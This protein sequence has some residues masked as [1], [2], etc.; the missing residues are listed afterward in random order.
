MKYD[1]ETFETTSGW[2]GTGSV[3]V[4]GLNENTE[5]IASLKEKSLVFHFPE[6]S[7][8]ESITKSV[9]ASIGDYDTVVF[10]L[11]SRE[12]RSASYRKSSDC[13]YKISFDADNEFFIR[14]F[15]TFTHETIDISG[16]SSIDRIK[17]TCL[18]DDEDYLVISAMYLEK[19]ELPIDIFTAISEHIDYMF[20]IEYGKGIL[21]G[22]LSGSA[23]D[24]NV[25]LL[26]NFIGRY[27]VILIDDDVNSE[28]HQLGERSETGFGLTDLFDGNF[29]VNNFTDAPVYLI[30]PARAG[31][32]S[33]E[34]EIQLPGFSVWGLVP[35]PVN[36]G[37]DLDTFLD[38]FQTLTIGN[39]DQGRVLRYPILV[40]CEARSYEILMNMS[41]L[42]KK[43]LDTHTLWI[44]GR[45][46]DI[47]YDVIPI[48]VEPTSSYDVIP[49]IQYTINVEVK[50]ELW[51]RRHLPI[52]G[53]ATLN[54]TP[55]SQG[56]LL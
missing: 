27:S 52:A 48:E 22:T 24:T 46:N 4:H 34:I 30:F 32:G 2:S 33:S 14:T 42:I 26:E 21:L 29:L 8:G 45:K 17:I 11:W 6:G 18:H 31:I 9:S 40:D 12:K 7:N 56:S 37:T 3:A 19:Q 53:A 5:Y 51:A 25:T 38:T 1:L 16:L 15:P 36:R 28:T 13:S 23:G 47:D 44:N 41:S 10:S 43:F 49:K 35:E 39:K 50:E 55:S 54:L 20:E